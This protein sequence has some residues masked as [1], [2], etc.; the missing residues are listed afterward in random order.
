MNLRGPPRKPKYLLATDSEPSMI[1]TIVTGRIAEVRNY[2]FY[3]D[4]VELRSCMSF[5]VSVQLLYSSF[6]LFIDV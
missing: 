2:G 4:K 3:R 5:S 6:S 1:T